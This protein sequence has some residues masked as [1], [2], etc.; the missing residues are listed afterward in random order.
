MIR[1]LINDEVENVL[2]KGIMALS[3]YH[4]R[5]SIELLRE[6][7]RNLSQGS[8]F[9]HPEFEGVHVECKSTVLPLLAVRC[10]EYRICIT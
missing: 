1:L 6:I 7:K 8:R 4:P 2:K 9:Q 10:R 5:I 3:K